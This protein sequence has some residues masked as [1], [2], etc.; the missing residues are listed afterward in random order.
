MT[1]FGFL[2]ALLGQIALLLA[3]AHA[4][5]FGRRAAICAPA[6]C[7]VQ[8][9]PVVAATTF[10]LLVPAVAVSFQYIEQKIITQPQPGSVGGAMPVS[11]I[12]PPVSPRYAALPYEEQPGQVMAATNYGHSGLASVLENRCASCHKAQA[13]GGV[14]LWDQFGRFSPSKNGVPLS[15]GHVYNTVVVL[16]TM[17]MGSTLNQIEI[18]AMNELI[19]QGA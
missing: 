18:A 9:V 17:P 1:R 6:V 2:A 10:E 5:A 7:H 4:F 12:A 8:A 11:T 19:N 16:R 15:N 14:R 13:K 3:P